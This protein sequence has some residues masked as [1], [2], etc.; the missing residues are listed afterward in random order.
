M[1][2]KESTQNPKQSSTQLQ[3]SKLQEVNSMLEKRDKLLEKKITQEV[4]KAKAFLGDG[5]KPQGM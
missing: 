2:N 5:N 4:E 1:G 3:I